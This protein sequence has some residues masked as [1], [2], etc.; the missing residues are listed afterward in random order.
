MAGLPPAAMRSV[1]ASANGDGAVIHAILEALAR[2]RPAGLAH[3]VPQLGPQRAGRL[4]VD[5]HRRRRARR[6]ASAAT[7]RPSPPRCCKAAAEAQVERQPV[8]LCLYDAPLPEPLA[9]VRS[10][11]ASFG[12]ALVLLPA[13]G[14]GALARLGS[15]GAP[16]PTR[17]GEPAA[18]RRRCGALHAQQP[19]GPHPAAAGGA[20]ARGRLVARA[21]RC[22]TGRSSSMCTPCSTGTRIRRADPAPGRDV[23]AR[24]A[25]C[26]WDAAEIVCAARSHLDPAN[27]LRQRGPAGRGRAASNTACRRRRCTARCSAGGAPQ[28]ARL[29]RRACAASPCTSPRLDDPGFRRAASHRPDARGAMPAGLAYRFRLPPAGGEC[30]VEGRGLIALP[31]GPDAR[32]LNGVSEPATC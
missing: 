15:P 2:R 30:L 5:R 20:G 9:R 6:P 12:A 1:F 28:P 3:A 32:R 24:R 7:T 22:W 16:D 21:S 13:P 11:R 8:L 27:P 19:G 18:A 26:A 31:R 10:G 4:L 17:G 14:P 25:C 23:P 29:P